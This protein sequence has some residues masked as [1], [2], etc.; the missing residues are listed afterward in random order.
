[1]WFLV[2]LVVAMMVYMFKDKHSTNVSSTNV[3]MPYVQ[4][5]QEITLNIAQDPTDSLK[6]VYAPPLRYNDAD[7]RQIGYLKTDNSPER[8]PLIGRQVDRNDRWT[9]YTLDGSIKLPIEHQ[10]RKCTQTPGC[11][12]LS[13]KD[14]VTVDGDNYTV[15]MYDTKV[16][17]Y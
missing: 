14:Q 3:K 2:V 9:Y 1:M 13:D 12:S 6:N 7:F 17:G 11:Y 4:Q 16:I 15:T 5:P 8:L 10:N